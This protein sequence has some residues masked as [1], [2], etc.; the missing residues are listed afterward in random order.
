MLTFLMFFYLMDECYDKYQDD[1]LGMFLSSISPEIWE[2]GMPTERCV[3][4]DWR[5]LN[6]DIMVNEK[7]LIEISAYFLEYYEKEHSYHLARAK[8]FL[9]KTANDAMVRRATVRAQ[10]MCNKHHYK[11]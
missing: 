5:R 2:D 10:A 4:E 3:Y 9:R 8:E 7:N 1:D 11:E 6:K